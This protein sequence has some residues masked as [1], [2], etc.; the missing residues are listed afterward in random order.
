MSTYEKMAG[1]GTAALR[2]QFSITLIASYI[3]DWILLVALAV[4]SYVLG[5]IKPN[6][7]NF[8]LADPN[9]ACVPI[10]IEPWPMRFAN[11][12]TVAAFLLPSTRPF[13]TCFSLSV[14]ASSP[15]S[16]CS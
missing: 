4:G 2:Q 14:A 12:S 1:T 5:N 8:S 11:N 13:P 16:S 10:L 9:I 3:I 7:R 6:F 15:S